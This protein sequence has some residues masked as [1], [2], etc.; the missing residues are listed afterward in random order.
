MPNGIRGESGRGENPWLKVPL[1]DYEG[2]MRS[3]GVGQ[4]GALAELF[5]EVLT[6]SRPESVAILGIA[7][8]NGLEHID[9]A[10]TR[11]VVGI[12]LNPA[13]LEVVRQRYPK[14]A[15]LELHC[16]DLSERITNIEPVALVHAALVFEH[17]GTSTALENSVS[18]VA[19]GGALSIVLQLTA[20]TE[21]NVGRSPFASVR[22]FE[23][24][25]TPID[26]AWITGE[27]E[28]RGF[29]LDSESHRALPAG[30]SFWMGV[31]VRT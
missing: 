4:L 28:R 8:G 23:N 22:V 25:F 19:P 13:Y 20:A 24:H 11:R 30:K 16:A 12:D 17:V 7:G 26:P 21:P 1:E 2:H 31:F 10:V 5:A 18:L 29:R 14:L 9:A 15:G 6:R 27:I 3:E